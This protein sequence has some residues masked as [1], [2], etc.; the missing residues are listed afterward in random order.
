MGYG[1][2]KPSRPGSGGVAKGERAVGQSG[3]FPHLRK[4][5]QR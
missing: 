4:S 5:H 1:D 3:E 2:K